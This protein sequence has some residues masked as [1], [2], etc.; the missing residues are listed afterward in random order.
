MSC[1]AVSCEFRMVLLAGIPVF[2]RVWPR[3][4]YVFVRGPWP[5]LHP[6]NLRMSYSTVTK[7]LAIS[8][9]FIYMLYVKLYINYI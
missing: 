6:V 2:L 3:P 4:I 8:I 7:K 5:A 9:Y 1:S